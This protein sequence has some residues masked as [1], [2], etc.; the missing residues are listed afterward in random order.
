MSKRKNRERAASGWIFREGKLWRKEDW[1]ERH[2]S[3]ER[4]EV[5]ALDVVAKITPGILGS[6]DSVFGLRRHLPQGGVVV[7]EGKGEVE[8]E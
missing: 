3:K 2:I 1:G 5:F 4:A 6:V 7:I 8:S